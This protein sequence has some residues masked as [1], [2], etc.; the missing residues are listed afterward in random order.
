MQDWLRSRTGAG[1][2][3]L[4]EGAAV[5]SEGE[6]LAGWIGRAGAAVLVVLGEDA[7]AVERAVERAAAG[8]PRAALVPL[9]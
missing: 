5:R 8:L 7:V 4:E 1:I 2:E 6:R 3:T 9:G